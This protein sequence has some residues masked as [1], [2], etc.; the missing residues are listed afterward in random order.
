MCFFLF[1]LGSRW[2]LATAGFGDLLLNALALEFIL[3]LAE[4]L[5][6]ALAP[7]QQKLKVQRTLIPQRQSSGIIA[8]FVWVFSA[9]YTLAYMVYFQGVLP[10]YKW[11]VRSVCQSLLAE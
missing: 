11:D 2:L 1:W 6:N 4:I 8:S 5:Y 9:V 3:N 7:F 10:D